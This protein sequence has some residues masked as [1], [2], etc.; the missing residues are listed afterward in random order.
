M[1]ELQDITA[2][3]SALTGLAA[4]AEF[5]ALTLDSQ[6]ALLA[7]ASEVSV[8]DA[9]CHAAELIYARQAECGTLL[10]GLGAGLAALATVNG[11]HGL[12]LDGRGVGMMSALR[13][14]AG[15]AHPTDGAWPDPAEDPEPLARYLSA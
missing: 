15:E 2:A 10:L 9:V 11:W 5:A 13:R 12:A 4:T 14:E 7:A 6:A 8:V 3:R 1:I